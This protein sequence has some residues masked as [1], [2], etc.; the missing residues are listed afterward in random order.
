MG[1]VIRPGRRVLA[2]AVTAAALLVVPLSG[3]PAQA[4]PPRKCPSPT[5]DQAINRADVVF[6]GQVKKVRGVTGQGK[7][8]TRTYQVLSDRVYQSSLVQ[9]AVVVTA[10]AG[11]RCALP[12]LVE[13][14]RY[15]FFVQESGARLMAVPPT[16][17]ATAKLTRQVESK[18]GSGAQPEPV[19]PATAELTPVPHADPPALTRLLAPGAALLII[20]L[21][22]LLVV[23]RLGRR[24]PG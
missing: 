10:R 3:S 13:G 4:A 19:P 7:Q 17:K 12:K 5:L 2:A 23:G 18:L 9:P 24:T 1:R 16:G 22:G 21:L 6:R 14:G 8:R 20:S 15:L 11:V